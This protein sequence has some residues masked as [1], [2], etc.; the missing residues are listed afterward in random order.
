V[1]ETLPRHRFAFPLLA[2]AFAAIMTGTT[3]PTPIYAV[4]GEELHFSVLTTTVIYATYAGGVLFALVMFGR[5]SDAVG[6]RPVLLA[7]VACAVASGVVFLFADSVAVLLVGRVL[8]GFSA[9]LFAGTATAAVIEAAPPGW[10][11]RAASVATVSNIGAL[12]I[13]PLLSGLL[14]EYAPQPLR[15]SY[16]VH[17]VLALLA[18]AAVASVPETSPRSGSIGVQRVSVPPEVR[19]VFLIAAL[20]AFAGF[21]VTGLFTAVAPSFLANVIGIG[22]HAV[23]GLIVS[24]IFFASAV[25]QVASTNV[26]PQRAVAVGC[27]ILVVGMVILA[28]ALHFSSLIAL[29]AAAVVSGI[30]QG[31]SFSRGLAAVME[32]TPPNC[33]AEVSSTY[34]VVAY[35]AISLPVVGEGLASQAWGLRTSGLT[36]AVLVAVLAIACL[37]AILFREALD[38]RR[39][40]S[41]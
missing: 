10:R 38:A 11:T 7:G 15:L 36:F 9:G 29:V 28:G 34:F 24:S 22:N 6:R 13:G 21:S 19:P 26:R 20:A 16:A 5:W 30:G 2:Y 39:A 12:G 25:G 4:Y 18:A 35:V 27:T 23:A 17:I 31:V 8:S 32:L 40:T 37:G 1:L 41:A 14:V 33:R 3:L